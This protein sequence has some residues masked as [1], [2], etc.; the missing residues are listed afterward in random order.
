VLTLRSRGT[1][2]FRHAD[3]EATGRTDSQYRNAVRFQ[4]PSL[5]GSYPVCGK[6][7]VRNHFDL[8]SSE[9][10]ATLCAFFRDREGRIA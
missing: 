6:D 3:D 4:G 5:H 1:R 9:V 10:N 7:G 8:R 2:Y